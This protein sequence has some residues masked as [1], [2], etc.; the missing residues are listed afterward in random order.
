[1]ASKITILL[2]HERSGSHFVSEYISSFSG[3]GTFDEVCNPNAIVPSRDTHS[4]FRFKHDYAKENPDFALTPSRDGTERFLA[5]YFELLR[6]KRGQANI[7]VDIKYGHVHQFEVFWWPI[8]ARPNLFG[9]CERNNIQI[10][11]LYRRNVV[12]SAVS[13]EIAEQRRVWHTWQSDHESTKDRSHTVN[14]RKIIEQASLLRTQSDWFE[15]RWIGNAIRH[16]ITYEEASK[17]IGTGDKF[18]TDL[19]NFVGGTLTQDY[20]RKHEKVTQP[21]PLAVE[22]FEA[23]QQ[24]CENAGLGEFL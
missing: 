14:V 19:A 9:F 8:F 11:H 23:L 3:V 2:S 16:T 7:V 4:F 5:A 12:E 1:V 15:S 18:C 10:L 24:A 13:A 22:N 21:L 6:K 20:R 17:S